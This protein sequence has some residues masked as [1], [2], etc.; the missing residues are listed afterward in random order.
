MFYFVLSCIPILVV[1]VQVK[2][3]NGGRQAFESM[4]LLG[5]LISLLKQHVS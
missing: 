2:K 4:S 3:L 5:A 1:V